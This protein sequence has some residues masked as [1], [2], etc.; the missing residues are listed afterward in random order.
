VQYNG[1]FRC[2]T[3]I[4]AG[5]VC[6]ITD[7]SASVGEDP[8]RPAY[9]GKDGELVSN[10]YSSDFNINSDTTKIVVARIETL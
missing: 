4:S 3:H 5:V 7:I 9:S 2:L 1:H 6:S 10:F 8:A